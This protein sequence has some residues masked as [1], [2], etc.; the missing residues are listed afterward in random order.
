L[1][2]ARGRFR[3]Y[4]YVWLRNDNADGLAS[5]VD[6]NQ[7]LTVVSIVSNWGTRKVI[8]TIVQKGGFADNIN[9]PDQTGERRV[10]LYSNRNSGEVK[11]EPQ[12]QRE[13]TWS[14]G[15]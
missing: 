1:S 4:Y 8:E 5:T 10:S 2:T 13:H 11:K 15:F 6:N 14:C 3:G 7:T 12:R 9:D